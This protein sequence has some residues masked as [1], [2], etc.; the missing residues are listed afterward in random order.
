MR[1][2]PA[3]RLEMRLKLISCEVFY[4]EM[5]AASAR[6][7]NHIE[8]DFFAPALHKDG[9]AQ[10]RKHLQEAIDACD[11]TRFQAVLLGYGLCGVDLAGL[12]ARSIPLVI[13][14]NCDCITHLLR[15][16]CPSRMDSMRLRPA[17]HLHAGAAPQATKTPSDDDFQAVHRAGLE[18]SVEHLAARYG[19]EVARYFT[20][21][22][23]HVRNIPLEKD[24]MGSRRPTVNLLAS[25]NTRRFAHRAISSPALGR[26]SLPIQQLVDGYWSYEQFLV[27]PPQWQVIMSLEEGITAVRKNHE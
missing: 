27:V 15:Q 7:P 20:D 25:T 22:F 10:K 4:R 18:C 21:G 3:L 24:F 11:T 23:R 8:V 14:R 17:I 12:Q 19:S 16:Q 9:P 5:A 6:S 13:P 26:D 2:V 1:A